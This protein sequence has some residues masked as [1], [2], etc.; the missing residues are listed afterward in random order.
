MKNRLLLCG[1]KVC[2]H[3]EFS[4]KE[5]R[6]RFL[7]YLNGVIMDI[8][9]SEQFKEEVKYNIRVRPSSILSTIAEME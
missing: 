6:G 7:T 4:D 8:Y 1:K 5:D 2:V 3:L 9:K